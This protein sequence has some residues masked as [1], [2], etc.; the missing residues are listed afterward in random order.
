VKRILPFLCYAA[1]LLAACR[2]SYSSSGFLVTGLGLVALLDRHI[3]RIVPWSALAWKKEVSVRA[4]SFLGGAAFFY[5]M[6]PG[7][8]PLWEAGYRG[9]MVCL[10]V[11]LLQSVNA[12]EGSLSR[13]GRLWLSGA[14]VFVLMLFVPV[15]AALHPLHTV[16][17]RTPAAFGLAFDDVRFQT[18]DGVELAG[19][20]IPHPQARGNVI[21]CHGHGRNRGHVAGLLQTFHDLGL[22]VLA[23][24]FRGHGDSA[25]H[26]STFGRDEVED[27]VAADK[28]LRH[29]CPDQPVMVVGVSLGAAVALQALPRMP[30][31]RGVWSEGAFARLSNPVESEFSALPCPLRDRLLGC[32]YLFGWLD[33]GLWGPAVN[34][35]ED[36]K[37]VNVPIFFCHGK[38]DELIPFTDAQ[39][40]YENYGGP[41]R[42]WLVEGASH[43][44]VRQ[45]NHEEYLRRLRGF[46]EECLND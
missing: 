40:L 25:G 14:A 16:P 19:W 23:F 36:I 34:P 26:T 41:K 6:R 39:A 27:L 13:R 4:G 7:V 18:A 8:V 29:R 24:D 11:V 9:A 2:W 30:H 44:D 17:K 45:R 42:L 1:V 22:N 46:L 3:W 33:C 10:A 28:Y 20:L 38:E 32:Y 5:F 43:Y 31:V 35:T 12:A 15:V 37:G 21:F